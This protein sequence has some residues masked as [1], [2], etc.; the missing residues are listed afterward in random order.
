MANGTEVTVRLTPQEVKVLM[1]FDKD[2]SKAIHKMIKRYTRTPKDP[3]AA[4]AYEYLQQYVPPE[5]IDETHF[6]GILKEWARQKLHE[7]AS[8]GARQPPV[9]EYDVTR[10]MSDVMSN[11]KK[12]SFYKLEIKQGPT[13]KERIV[14]I[15]DFTLETMAEI[16]QLRRMLQFT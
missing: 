2:L 10:L 7:M 13:G 14:K 8:K 9:T 6:L 12:D 5:G 4:Q 15:G 3:I 1:M 11:L 16:T